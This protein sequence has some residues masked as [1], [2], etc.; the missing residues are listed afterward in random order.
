MFI[1]DSY[2]VIRET[3]EYPVTE[4]MIEKLDAMLSEYGVPH[5]FALP[6]A[7]PET[8]YAKDDEVLNLYY[9]AKDTKVWVLVYALWLKTVREYDDDEKI[10]DAVSKAFKAIS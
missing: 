9:E 6:N 5:Y 10:G 8:G 2:H 3:E 1:A 7:D 4:G